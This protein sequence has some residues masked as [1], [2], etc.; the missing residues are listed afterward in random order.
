LTPLQERVLAVLAPMSPR[1]TLTGGGA[2]AG[3][4]LGH[5]TTRDLDLFWH[6]RAELGEL[7]GEVLRRLEAAGLTAERVQTTP[8]FE[9]MRVREAAEE[10]IL[11]LV[12]ERVP[13]VAAPLEVRIGDQ[14][15]LID[16]AHEI[17]VNKLGTLLQRRELRDLVDV[18]ALLE[19]G[20]DL[21]TALRD[22]PR[23]DGGFSPL[24]V[25][26]ILESFPVA[27]LA[28]LAGL[29]PAEAREL[30]TFKLALIARLTGSG[31]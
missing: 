21:A 27:D 2:L 7:P 29:T 10:L 12:A 30:E 11:D 13:T 1:W 18:R 17:L 25:A 15:V 9:R 28:P 5:R 22:A 24:M 23:K 26:W 20:G 6:G 14:A 4:H 31:E 8:A 19:H 16:S 3:F